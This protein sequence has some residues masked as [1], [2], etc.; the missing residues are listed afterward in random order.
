L[1]AAH[2]QA[3]RNTAVGSRLPNP[4]ITKQMAFRGRRIDKPRNAILAGRV[5]RGDLT[6]GLPQI[7]A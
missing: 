1:L 5:A 3:D 7:R 6:P 2:W 4:C